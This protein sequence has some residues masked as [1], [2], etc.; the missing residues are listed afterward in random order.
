[1]NESQERSGGS[2]SD[3]GNK[4]E[5]LAPG[6][7]TRRMYLRKSLHAGAAFAGA[8]FF[9]SLTTMNVALAQGSSFSF[10]WVSDTHL[11]PKTLN[12]RFVEKAVRAFKDVSD[13]GN[14]LDFL[15]FGGDLAQL[16]DP[17]EINLGADL[18]KEVKIKKY[19]I[20]GEHDWYLDM[21]ALWEKTF[22]GSPWK[23]DHK[24]VRFI[25]LNTVG[26]AP[27]YWTAKKMTP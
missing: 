5:I 26:F 3:D 27:D 20:P 22:G 13:M 23:F 8:A 24:G 1:M 25:G 6:S 15:I 12:T 9:D 7:I 4:Q 17:V 11:Y 16:G 14:K 10:A 2:T 18:L 21:G 19:F